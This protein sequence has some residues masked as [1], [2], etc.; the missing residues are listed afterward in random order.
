MALAGVFLASLNGTMIGSTV[1]SVDPYAFNMLRFAIVSLVCMPFIWQARRILFQPKHFKMVVLA[2]L[3]VGVSV[4]AYARAIQL[5]QASYVSIIL[6]LTPIVLLVY[7]VKMMREK[8][9]QRALTG[10]T[11]AAIGAMLLVILPIATRQQAG[12]TFY[13]AATAIA[14]INCFVFPM[15]IIQLRKANEGGVPMVP[16]VGFSSVIV[17]AVSFVLFIMFGDNQA[18]QLGTKDW[19]AVLFSG[20]AVALLG[21]M[22]KVWSYEHV[23]AA[24]TGSMMYLETLLS[25]VIPVI[26]LHEQLSPVVVVGGALVLLG[27]YVVESHRLFTHRHHYFWHLH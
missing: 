3:C 19:L 6:L 12:V 20:L 7:S 18:V 10:I 15:A 14:L 24:A 22:F 17:T 21:R 25:I 9:T 27:V 11:L 16:L 23:G 1:D 2:G 8:L 13:P 5:S 4:S 26:V